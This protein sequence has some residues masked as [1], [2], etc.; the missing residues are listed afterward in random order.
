MSSI[1]GIRLYT[2]FWHA[3]SQSICSLL[4]FLL[5][6]S[7]TASTL[8]PHCCGC[9]DQLKS[10][11]S[12][13]ISEANLRT[14]SG[15]K[16]DDSIRRKLAG[17]ESLSHQFTVVSGQYLHLTVAQKGINVAVTL[18]APNGKTL[19][20][21]NNNNLMYGPERLSWIAKQTGIYKLRVSSVDRYAI[22]GVYEI[23]VDERRPAKSEDKVRVAAVRH[24]AAATRYSEAGDL[25]QALDAYKAARALWR[26]DSDH[27]EEANV[28]NSIGYIYSELGDMHKAIEHYKEALSPAKYGNA[29]FEEASLLNNLGD[30]YLDLGKM[31]VALDYYTQALPLRR[32]T[33]DRQGEAITLNSI[34]VANHYLGN[35]QSSYD[36]LQQALS[37]SRDIHDRQREAHILL[38]LAE[39]YES[40]NEHDRALDLL[41]YALNCSRE[42]NDRRSEVYVLI[43]MGEIYRSSG[44]PV[45][46]AHVLR[47]ALKQSWKI[48]DYRGQSLSLSKL[49]EVYAKLG[50]RA[51]SLKYYK[52]ALLL[53]RHLGDRK[54]EVQTLYAIGFIHKSSR[55]YKEAIST[56]NQA[57]SLSQAI[58]DQRTEANTLFLLAQVK[59]EQGDFNESLKTI[60][61]ALQ[62]T[63]ST[64]YKI[65]GQGLRASYSDSIQAYYDFY[66]NVLMQLHKLHPLE[67]F[68][69][70]ALQAS[71]RAQARSLY[72]L[73]TAAGV[74]T[75][76]GVDP[77]LLERERSLRQLLNA[78]ADYQMSVLG[79]KFKR[80]ET[81]EIARELGQ[82]TSEYQE[83]QKQIRQQNPRY[84]D[85]TRPQPV[86]LS[87]IQ[88]ELE[89]GNTVLL[90]YKLGDKKSYLWAVTSNSINS[91][92]LPGRST[93][94]DTAREVYT[95]ITARQR[96]SSDYEARVSVADEQY[97][98]KASVLS[99]ML[100]GPVAGQLGSKRLLIIS[101]GMLQYIPFEALPIPLALDT[102]NIRP[103]IVDHEIVHLPSAS[104]L[105]SL[106]RRGAGR[107]PAS[108][109]VAVMADPIYEMDD[110]RIRIHSDILKA[111]S[112][113]AENL[114]TRTGSSNSET[115]NR[116]ASFETAPPRISR[117]TATL[118]EAEAILAVSP[119]NKS[120][121]A[122]GIEANREVVT[123]NKLSDYRIIHFATHGIIN[124]KNPELS[125]IVL[126]Q[127]DDRGQPENG[128]LRLSD[129]YN[130]DLSADLVVLSA[131]RTGLEKEFKGEGL[132][133]LTQGFMHSGAQSVVASLWKVDDRATEDLMA[134]FYKGMMVER[135]SPASALR[136][137]QIGMWKQ[138]RW[139][140]PY[141]WAA[142][143]LQGDWDREVAVRPW[144]SNRFSILYIIMLPLGISLI[145]F[146]IIRKIFI[147]R[148]S[149]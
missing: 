3:I 54:A 59:Y 97:W 58:A 31:S 63:D 108:K 113:G 87:E 32:S 13:Q 64:R 16:P 19:L 56:L 73:L 34:G 30:A 26:D 103:L 61:T 9:Q 104:V 45:R 62:I 130:L 98:K 111:A 99:Q 11:V 36:S 5:W 90:E 24:L 7:I 71:E 149:D 134:L 123:S 139:Q 81:E 82:L 84:E 22:S 40:L 121:A 135:L 35:I 102:E 66:I 112:N 37:I 72:E 21:V 101:D 124:D 122:I 57:L 140:S 106:R 8:H 79:N 95:L 93:I 114:A 144:D 27:L 115:S 33:S 49:G 136:K 91:Y 83:V 116:Q 25:Y 46:T 148:H 145:G 96:S 76:Y 85:L 17:G 70:S 117:L 127:F 107:K 126:S 109:A 38:N 141:Y 2:R 92:E 89:G 60:E 41:K 52:E 4:G 12:F 28:L 88:A 53:N 142:F 47:Q 119:A 20:L 65:A 50:E 10:L 74:N 43:N 147:K 51:Q 105:V 131:C 44:E 23:R 128:L 137:A 118:R 6:I 68:D 39:I 69:T 1:G 86:N 42:S 110:P 133:G 18:L 146:C 100:L 48:S 67:G 15:P 77:N 29:Q 14:P 129:I 120:L 125:G 55:K 132:T 78:K 138:K 143:T 80:T 75:H 94:E